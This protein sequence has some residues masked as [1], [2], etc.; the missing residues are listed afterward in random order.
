MPKSDRIRISCAAWAGVLLMTT[1]LAAQTSGS[2]TSKD[3]KPAAK[4]AS[5]NPLTLPSPPGGERG[6]RTHS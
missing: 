3:E 2:S 6:S 1:A 5:E 4:S